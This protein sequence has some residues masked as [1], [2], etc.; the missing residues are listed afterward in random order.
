MAAELAD[1]EGLPGREA[2]GPVGGHRLEG[3]GDKDD[4]RLERDLLAGEAVGIAAAV[5]ALVVVAH[6]ARLELHVG[7]LD[8]VVAQ[9][10]VALHVL[11]LV[12]GELGGL[13]EDRVGDADLAH[14]V[15]QPGQAQAREPPGLEAQLGADE[16][17]QLRDGL[18]V[19]A[20][21]GVLGVDRARQR[22]GQRA[23]VVLVLLRV[24]R[25][26]PERGRGRR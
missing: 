8:D 20:R 14:V 23:R 7:G 12:V 25:R 19:A 21:V 24:A 22:A 4:A 17:A 13:V 3:V 15:Q 18:A 2:I 26:R 6:P 10:R 16:P 5:E 1:R 9:Q 11:V